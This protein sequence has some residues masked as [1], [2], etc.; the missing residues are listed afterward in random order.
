[1]RETVRGQTVRIYFLLDPNMATTEV[2]PEEMVWG[3]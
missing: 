2:K 3:I 1:M